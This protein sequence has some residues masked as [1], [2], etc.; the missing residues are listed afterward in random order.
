[1]YKSI[2]F[3]VV[4][5]LRNYEYHVVRGIMRQVRNLEARIGYTVYRVYTFQS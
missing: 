1:M 2:L 3:K 5:G 4:S